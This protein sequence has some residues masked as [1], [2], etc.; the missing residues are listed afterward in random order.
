MSRAVLTMGA[1]A[2]RYGVTQWQVRRLFERRLLP[3]PARVGAYRVV[4]ESDL[5]AVE[6]ALREAGYLSADPREVASPA[7]AS[8]AI[9]GNCRSS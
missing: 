7:P 3:E 2:R 8:G 6:R 5:P 4:D 1:I 9:R